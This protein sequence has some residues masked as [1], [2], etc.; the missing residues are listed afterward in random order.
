ME[1]GEDT[2]RKGVILGNM[3]EG[4]TENRRLF[5]GLQCFCPNLAHGQRMG[6]ISPRRRADHK[7]GGR[8]EY[9]GLRKLRQIAL[10]PMRRFVNVFQK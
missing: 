9:S 3:A 6:L 5:V 1:T 2:Q 10:H 7:P 8:R 4:E